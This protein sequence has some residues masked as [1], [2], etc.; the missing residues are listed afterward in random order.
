MVHPAD[1]QG[2]SL[3]VPGD[4]S[5]SHRIAMLAGLASGVSQVRNY[6]QAE[7][8]INT[9]RAMEALGARSSFSENGD[10]EI[11]GTGGKI[12]EPVGPLNLG[13]SGT[14]MRLLAGLMSGLPVSVEM[15]GDASLCSRPMGRI[16]APLEKMGATIELTGER[17]CAPIR[18]KGGHL[19]AI[20]YVLPVASAQVKSCVLFAGLFAE[21]TTTVTEPV[22]TRDHTERLMKAMGLPL[23][24][25]GLKISIQGF[26]SKG[27]N[28]M[29]RP[30]MAPGDFSSAAYWMAAAAIKP[31]AKVTIRNVGLNARRTA[32]LDVLKRMGAEVKI[33]RTSSSAD[34]EVFGDITVKGQLL[35]GTEIGGGEIPNLIDEIPIIAVVGALAEGRTVIR[36]AAELRVKES[37]RIAVMAANLRL[38]GVNVE[39]KPDGME[40]VGPTDLKAPSNV[41]SFGDHRIA[42]SMAILALQAD[43]PVCINNVACVETSYPGFWDDMKRLGV[44]VE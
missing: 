43:Q 19:K 24:V 30:W 10:L 39:E 21:G 18:V 40:I 32:L 27:L 23:T 31:G 26:G 13:N 44:N 25:D 37:D 20:D 16:K 41:N 28:L 36:D 17:G 2:G 42:M 8:C 12:L 9:L 7:D 11:H 22:A 35:K 6:L 1:F 15:T 34:A 14:G 5:I 3:E 33:Q 38:F 4:K 29:A